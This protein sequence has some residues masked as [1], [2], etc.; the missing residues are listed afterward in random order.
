MDEKK[1]GKCKHFEFALSEKG[2]KCLKR[3]GTCG[4]E[5]PWPDK[6]PKAF[7]RVCDWGCGHIKYPPSRPES[8]EISPDDESPCDF[9]LEKGSKR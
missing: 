8:G 9:F 4:W 7:L 5:F 2:K 3:A 6:W 1:C